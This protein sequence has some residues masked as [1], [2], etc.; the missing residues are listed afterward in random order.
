MNI[1]SPQPTNYQPEE[2]NNLRF[3]RSRFLYHVEAE[4]TD[5]YD[6]FSKVSVNGSLTALRGKLLMQT[7]E[8]LHGAHMLRTHIFC[9]TEGRIP[10][11]I[12]NGV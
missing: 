9:A 10:G 12:V 4:R 5:R 3:L 1:L 11:N 6:L 8:K 7:E 2:N